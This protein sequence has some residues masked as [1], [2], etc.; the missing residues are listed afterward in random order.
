MIIPGDAQDNS[1]PGGDGYGT[2]KVDASGAILFNGSLADGSKVSQS[3]ALSKQGIW[4]LYAPLYGGQGA[5][6]SWLQF[7][8]QTDSD[9]GGQL[10]WLKVGQASPPGSPYYPLGFTNEVA[11][12]GSNYRPPTPGTRALNMTAGTVVLSG[13]GLHEPLT[14]SITLAL[15]NRATAAPA[16]KFS[17]TITPSTGLF[18][19][20]ALN[21]ETGKTV[22]FQG[23]LFRKANIG[24]GYFLGADQSG[25]VYLS[26][27]P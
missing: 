17:L 16:S 4:P 22:P 21:P 14:N 5:I 2:V 12:T 6:I 24:V 18:K 3:S 7:T 8:N 27:A 15:N 25:E 1:S 13:G 23:I 11:V 19:G 26:P 20:S 9:L 10:L